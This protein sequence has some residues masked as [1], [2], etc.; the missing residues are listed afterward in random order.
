VDP[1][2]DDVGVRAA[3]ALLAL[4]LAAPL[5]AAAQTAVPRPARP[6]VLPA[7]PVVIVP[8]HAV[9]PTEYHGAIAYHRATGA[10][11]YSFDYP[12]SREAGI[13]AINGCG[14]DQCLIAIAF[15]NGC[16]ALVDGP[17]GPVAA[18][19]VNARE[20]EVK[21]RGRCTDPQCQVIAWAC[22]R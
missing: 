18:E 1:R 6:I 13:A 3:R 8:G 9:T 16:A 21:A 20:A 12:T 17:S 14:E 5:A 10:F 22:T 4:V 19:G 15:K 7:P 2:R 11:G